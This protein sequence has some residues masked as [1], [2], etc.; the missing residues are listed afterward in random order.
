MSKLVSL[1]GRPPQ[2]LLFDLDGTLVD[3]VPDLAAAVDAMLDDQGLPAAGEER[4]RQWVGNGAVKL[5]QRALA[6]GRVC[7]ESE[8]ENWQAAHRQFLIHYRGCASHYSRLYDGV[9]QALLHWHKNHISMAVVTNKPLNFVPDILQHFGIA[10][11]FQFLVGGECLPERKPSAQPLLHACRQLNVEPTRALMVGDS[12]NDIV[13]A[14]AAAMPV[15]AV[16]YGY[17][18]GQPIEASGPDW[19]VDSLLEL[20]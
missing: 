9:E 15:V 13:A 4:V 5:V 8:L 1:L 20:L 16:S 6:Y 2:A 10:H 11:C 12:S 7:S 19:V 3:S 14:R 18:H 17:N